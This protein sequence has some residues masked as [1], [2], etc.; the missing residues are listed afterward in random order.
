MRLTALRCLALCVGC[1]K[2]KVKLPAQS[3]STVA[4]SQDAQLLFAID[5][6]SAQVSVV[7]VKSLEKLADVQ[8]GAAPAVLVVGADDTVYIAC[9]GARAV[10]VIHRGQ[11]NEAERYAAGPEPVG[12]AVSD[13]GRMLYVV[14]AIADDTPSH[15]QLLAQLQCLWPSP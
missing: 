6:D 12:L 8:V 13:D 4:L 10:S 14:S 5:A 15:G 3:A 7:D 1:G 11:W 9:R 2:P